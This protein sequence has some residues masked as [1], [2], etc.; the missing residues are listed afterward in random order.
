VR[1][2]LD[3]LHVYGDTGRRV[4]ILGSM[5]ELGPRSAELHREVLADAVGHGFDVVVATGDFATAAREMVADTRSGVV[6]HE[7]PEAGYALL[8]EHLDGE[9][10]ILLKASRGVALERLVSRF[11][12]DFGDVAPEAGRVVG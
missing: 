10:T 3:L 1:A 11:N 12:E 5:L 4:A 6:V 9:E 8:K 7:D 2:A